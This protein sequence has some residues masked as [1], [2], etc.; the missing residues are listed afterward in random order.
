MV[1]IDL[2]NPITRSG[3]NEMVLRI[4][5]VSQPSTLM[6]DFGNHNF[7]SI[8]VM[9]YCK[10]ELSKIESV[11][12]RFEKIGFLSIPPFKGESR[13]SEK[14]RYFHSEVKAKEWMLPESKGQ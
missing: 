11:M 8:D 4:L 9:K 12:L 14:L 10:L 1:K 5:E 6:I 3:V 2:E 13:D 7:E